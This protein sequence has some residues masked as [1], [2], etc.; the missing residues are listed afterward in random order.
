M[1]PTL[2][3]LGLPDLL[4]DPSALAA[5]TDEQLDQLAAVRDEA[6]D[7]LDVRPDDAE[8][9][10][11]VYIAHMTLTSALFLRALMADVQPQALPP[12]AVLERSWNGAALRPLTKESTVDMLVPTAT[13]DVLLKAG[14]PAHAEPG[15][16][17]EAAPVALVNIVDIPEDDADAS[18]DYFRAYWRVAVTENGDAICID[19]RGDGVVVLLDQEWGYYAQQYVNSSIG[20]FL[21]CLEAWRAMEADTSDDL[22]AIIGTFERAVERIDPAA[23]T[24]GAFWDMMLSEIDEDDSEES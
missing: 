18:R 17:F 4:E 24:E 20:H 9:I 14:L 5:L 16:T 10:D 13:L 1:H 2:A 7:A 21:L 3:S 15:I 22:D 23:L 6:A 8:Q 12:A 19:E 11:T